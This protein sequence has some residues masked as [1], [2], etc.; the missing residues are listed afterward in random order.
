MMIDSYRLFT[1]RRQINNFD[2][3]ILADADIVLV[4]FAHDNSPAQ[5]LL[6][7]YHNPSQNDLVFVQFE[8]RSLTAGVN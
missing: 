5:I 6:L 4:R 3:P 1:S 2:P 7:D 8:I